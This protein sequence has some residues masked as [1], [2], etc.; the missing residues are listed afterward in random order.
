MKLSGLIAGKVEVVEKVAK[1][2]WECLVVLRRLGLVDEA[3]EPVVKKGVENIDIENVGRM[4]LGE[5]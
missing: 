4:R 5:G 1:V 2:N 3:L